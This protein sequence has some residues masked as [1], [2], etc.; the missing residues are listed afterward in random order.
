[1]KAPRP[2]LQGYAGLFHG[3]VVDMFYFPVFRGYLP[4]WVPVLHG[5]YME[6]FPYIFNVADACITVGVVTVLLFQH[7]FLKED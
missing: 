6:F 5:R 1:M 7:R 3:R 4:D 2:R